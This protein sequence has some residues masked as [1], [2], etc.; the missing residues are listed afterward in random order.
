MKRLYKIFLVGMFAVLLFPVSLWCGANIKF[1]DKLV[2]KLNPPNVRVVTLENGMKCFFLEDHTIPVIQMG[3]L[4]KVGKIYEPADRVGLAILMSDLLRNGGAGGLPPSDFDRAI[5][6]IG[7]MLSSSIGLESYEGAVEMLA[8]DM[9]RGTRLFFDMV[10]LPGFDAKRMA[11]DKEKIIEGIRRE[12]DDYDILANR[13]FR[14]LIYGEDS[15]W[16]R[17]PTKKSVKSIDRNDVVKFHADYFKTNNTLLYAAG[18]FKINDFIAVITKYTKDLPRGEVNFPEIE[19]VK[20]NFE[21]KEELV[22]KKLTQSYIRIGHLGIKR[23]NQDKFA[24]SLMNDI[25][26]ASNFKS[27]LMEDIRTKRG[28]V[29]GISSDFS[30]SL[31]YGIFV[32]GLDT[33]ATQTTKVIDLVKGHIKDMMEGRGIKESELNFAKQSALTRLIFEFDSA[34]KVVGRRAHFAFLGYPD[35]YWQITRDKL[36]SVTIKDI[37]EVAAKYLHPDGLEIVIVG[38]RPK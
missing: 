14:K 1:Q 31:D 13:K 6:D 8:E 29:Y 10:F 38:P 18:D 34:F 22:E 25:L 36:A 3:V 37:K 26:G 16:S 12:D 19:A 24:I 20:L 4:I 11:V 9:D 30:S 23:D 5:E 33:K 15:V 17:R 28:L 7:A 2:P 32:V 35:N 27:R 21:P